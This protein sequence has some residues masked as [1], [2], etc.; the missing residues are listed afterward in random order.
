MIF[1]PA[2]PGPVVL[3]AGEEPF[4]AALR[5]YPR[6]LDTSKV[7]KFV[8]PI[9]REYVAKLLP[10]VAAT[11]AEGGLPGNT[12]RKVYLC[13]SPSNRPR[14]GDLLFFYETRSNSETSQ[15]LVSLGVV[16]A[17]RLTG[18]L[19]QLKRWT[20]KRS[21]FSDQELQ[22][23]VSRGPVKTIDFL[24]VAHLRPTLPLELLLDE[25]VL[26]SWPQSIVQIHETQYQKLKPHLKLGFPF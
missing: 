25:G 2:I 24:L 6:F 10:E 15:S 7:G 14:A 11:S 22:I 5:N 16:E 26:Q 1:D 18:D 8:V 23:L 4:A 19:A 9:H 13:H 3:A 20:A 17:V 21:V 12:I